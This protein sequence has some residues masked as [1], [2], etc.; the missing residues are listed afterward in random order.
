MKLKSYFAEMARI[1]DDEWT[2][3]LEEAANWRRKTEGGYASCL[4]SLGGRRV[5]R[6]TAEKTGNPRS[7]WRAADALTGK[8]CT[9]WS[10][11]ECRAWAQK[12]SEEYSRYRK[13]AYCSGIT[14]YTLEGKRVRINTI[15]PGDPVSSCFYK[16]SDDPEGPSAV[17]PDIT[18]LYISRSDAEKGFA[19]WVRKMSLSEDMFSIVAEEEV[20]RAYR[21]LTKRLIE[22][23]L[24]I[25][26]MESM[27][28]GQIA[29]LITDTEGSSKVLKGTFVTYSNE[30]KMMQGVPK[31]VIDRYT[32]YSRETAAA[33]AEACR[34]AYGSDLGIGVTGTAGNPD[35]SN[36]ETEELGSVYI[37]VARAE[38]KT[39]TVHAK[40]PHW[41]ERCMYKIAAADRVR[42]AVM[43]VLGEEEKKTKT[44][45]VRAYPYATQEAEFLVPAGL[46][47]EEEHAF[48][49]EHFDEIRF[50][51]PDLDYK[52]TDFEYFDAD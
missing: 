38:G 51:A 18:W 19:E 5:R 4:I 2:G 13:E 33:M 16:L 22:K 21:Q 11:G 10:L 35:P 26:T 37:A 12:E 32:V 39:V 25:S 31:E 14:A 48:I 24:T 30:A 20:R 27:T 7:P 36:P 8:E 6:F 29:S 15:S 41:K 44:V 34:K 52:G 40:I 23:G 3:G 1:S 28:G 45:C 46:S 9:C 42:E 50:G 47:P 43:D 49:E 17:C